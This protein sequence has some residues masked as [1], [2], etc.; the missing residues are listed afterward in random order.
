MAWVNA[1][2]L[3]VRL[4]FNFIVQPQTTGNARNILLV[5]ARIDMENVMGATP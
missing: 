3:K 1:L 2:S 4:I 5:E